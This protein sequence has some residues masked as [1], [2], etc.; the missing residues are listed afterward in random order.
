MLSCA[1]LCLT[2]KI[3]SGMMNSN[4]LQKVLKP[5]IKYAIAALLGYLGGDVLPT[6]F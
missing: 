6:I 3:L 2:L 1:S 5:V 4:F